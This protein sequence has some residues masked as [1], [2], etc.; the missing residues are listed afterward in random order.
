MT[1]TSRPV[2][3]GHQP[4]LAGQ[5]VVLIGGSSGIGFETARRAL[6]GARRCRPYRSDLLRS[7]RSPYITTN[8]AHT[9]VTS[10]IDG[11][12]QFTSA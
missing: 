5:T 2:P 11:G 6:G 12:Q 3:V 1:S 10:D 9:G 4:E 8:T 7:P